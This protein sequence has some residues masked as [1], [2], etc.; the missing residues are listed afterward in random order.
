MYGIKS[1][2]KILNNYEN[3][4]Q[5]MNP[6]FPDI[7]KSRM[8]TELCVCLY[9]IDILWTPLHYQGYSCSRT[10]RLLE[11]IPEISSAI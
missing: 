11:F 2:S 8:T 3:A 1:S 7:K 4:F 5:Y 10:V 9:G 6:F